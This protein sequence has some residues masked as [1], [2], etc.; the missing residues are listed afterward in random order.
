MHPILFT[1]ISYCEANLRFCHT[2]KKNPSGA[3]SLGEDIVLEVALKRTVP[4]ISLSLC[5]SK[6]GGGYSGEFVF[7]LDRSVADRDYYILKIARG[8]IGVGLYFGNLKLTIP[9][10]TLYSSGSASG[11]SFSTASHSSLQI[12]VYKPYDAPKDYFGGII[13]HVFVDRFSKGDDGAYNKGE[14]LVPD[15]SEGIAEYPEYPG[16]PMKNNTFYGG[17]LGGI[18][19]K[20]DYIMSLGADTIYLSPIFDA[21]SNHKY[22]TADYMTIDSAFG[23]ERSFKRLIRACHKRGIKVILDG[24]FNHTGADSI[25]FNRYSNYPS[26]GAYQSRDSEYAD[27]YEFESFPDKYK[28]WWDIEILPRLNL[29]SEGARDLI[30]GRGGVID[31]YTSLGVDGFRLDVADELSD[32]FISSIKSIIKTKSARPIL[33][34]EVWEDASNKIAYD[35]RKSY[36]NGTELDGVMNYPLRKGLIDYVLN[37]NTDALAYAIGEVYINAPYEVSNA[38]MNL[39]GTHDTRRILTVLGGVS[40]EGL[41]NSALKTLRMD[42]DTRDLA[43]R[44][45]MA[46][47]SVISMLPGIPTVFYADEAGLE[48][49]GDP[50]NR[51]PYPWGRADRQILSHY[52]RIGAIRKGLDVLK[53]GRFTLRYLDERLFVFERGDENGAIIVAYNNS[54]GDIRIA[55]NSPERELVSGK[56]DKDFVIP[57]YTTYIFKSSAE[58]FRIYFSHS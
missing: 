23:G 45:L 46:L 49:Y 27:W 24:V 51:M 22:D 5:L 8:E 53:L 43:K 39:L 20:L 50:F 3:F 38:Q 2:D 18:I 11:L 9:T 4:T 42:K 31:K 33:Y 52:R 19:K 57:P 13:Y 32:E 48:G 21:A 30:I 1:D 41:P 26:V 28:S 6:D 17:T 15:W 35:K 36:Y 7:L 25:Y 54:E 47:Y 12:S 56:L 40:A 37:K 10:K 16:A 14:V 29:K 44:R 55:F 34:G 58:D